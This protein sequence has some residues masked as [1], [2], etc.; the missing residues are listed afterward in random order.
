MQRVADEA[1]VGKRAVVYYYG[2]R[3][4]LLDAVIRHVGDRMLDELQQAVGGIEDPVEIVARGFEVVW[5]AITSDRALLAAWFGL[6]AEA[7]INPAFSGSAGYIGDRLEGIVGD[8][9]DAQLA[10]GRVLR[11]DR[12][13]L[14]VLV[15]ANV[16]GFA[17]YFLEHGDVP[18]LRAAITEFRHFLVTVAVP[19]DHRRERRRRAH[20]SSG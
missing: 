20:G 10:R 16:Q 5:G 14:R 1:G 15:V 2:T 18:P 9:I 8:A 11:V 17:A 4:G 6:H 19:G 13:V 7:V 3:E 12:D